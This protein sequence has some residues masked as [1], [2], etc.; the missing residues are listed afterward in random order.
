MKWQSL[1]SRKIHTLNEFRKSYVRFQAIPGLPQIPTS[2]SISKRKKCLR[3]MILLKTQYFYTHREKQILSR[4]NL[5]D[6][7]HKLYYSKIKTVCQVYI[8]P[9]WRPYILWD[10]SY[11]WYAWILIF[12]VEYS[13]KQGLPLSVLHPECQCF[14]TG[15]AP[16]CGPKDSLLENWKWEKFGNPFRKIERWCLDF[17]PGVQESCKVSPMTA[18]SQWHHSPGK[19]AALLLLLPSFPHSSLHF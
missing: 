5:H 7:W 14:L 6:I 11:S 2:L 16:Y 17:H 18:A 15:M 10:W 12:F 13:Y 3:S 4:E 8:L 1:C 19:G 9:P